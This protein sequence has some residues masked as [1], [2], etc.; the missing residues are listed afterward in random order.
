M[1][2]WKH[3]AQDRLEALLFAHI[4]DRAFPCVGAKSAMARG[5][6]DVLACSSIDSAWDD[7]RIHDALMRLAEDYRRDRAMYRSFAVVFEGPGDL[8][9]PEF[10][11]ALWQ[12]VQSLSDKD[13]WRGQDY[14]ARVSADPDNPHFS[15]SFGGEA[16]F[17]V[18][19]HPRASRPA[20]RFERPTLVFN[21]HDQFERLRA[22]GKYETMREKILVR[23]EALAGSRNPMLARHGAASEARQYSGRVV[24]ERWACPFHY[25]G[26]A[27]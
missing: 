14:D 15:L 2:N 25:S 7:V 16:F 23:D 13:V 10:E 6:L 1:F 19:L 21:L 24:D 12:R 20:R 11:R 27:K 3:E 17:I 4:D 8:S 26:E 9:E 5:T 18:G 22:E